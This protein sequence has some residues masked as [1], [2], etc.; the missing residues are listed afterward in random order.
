MKRPGVVSWPAQGITSGGA[1]LRGWVNPNDRATTYR[2]QYGTTSS[3]GTQ[4]ASASAGSSD[5][6][7]LVTAAVSALAPQT[8][9]HYRVVATNSKGTAYGVDL[10]FTTTE[11][12]AEP[13]PNDPGG[14]SG[15]GAGPPPSGDP[16]P[17]S[18]VAVTPGRGTVRVRVRGSSEFVP[19]AAGSG[20]PFGSEVDTTKGSIS[21]TS[22]LP[23]G[24]SQTGKFGGGRFVIRSGARGYIDLHLRGRFCSRPLAQRGSESS[25]ASA[26]ASRPQRR[27]WG[28]DSGGRF[29]THGKHSHATVRGTRWL[30]ED[31][32]N[33]TLTRVTKGSVVVRDFALDK[34]K[35]LRAGES[36][37]ARARR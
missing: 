18:T 28:S 9:Y 12:G 16:Q 35:I 4:T 1:L 19:L 30:V 36:Y 29:R 11:V 25:Y 14:P 2:F 21:L 31:R 13:A 27:L 33:G 8:T 22:V 10:T 34:R 24:A 37:L 20:L 7:R 6:W 5:D 32:C 3:Y 17:G 15:P 26:S 23:S